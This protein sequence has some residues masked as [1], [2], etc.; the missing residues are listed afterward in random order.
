MRLPLPGKAFAPPHRLPS[1][2][3]LNTHF[4]PDPGKEYLPPLSAG[5]Y[6]QCVGSRFAHS[7]PAAKLGDGARYNEI[8]E[9][10]GIKIPSKIQP[11]LVLILPA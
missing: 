6:S 3:E 11:G 7:V 10:N 8:A 9:L 5:P 1:F 4:H 2:L